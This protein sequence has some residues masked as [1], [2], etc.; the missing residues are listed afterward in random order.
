[1]NKKILICSLLI[2]TVSF[3]ADW[4]YVTTGASESF[5][6]DRSFYK[7]DVKNKTVDV[8]SKTVKKKLYGD[9]FYTSSKS[10]DR[11]SCS[12]KE[13]KGLA[14]VQYHDDGNVLKSTTV[15]DRNF[16]IIFP[17]SIAESI[18]NVACVTN[19]KGFKFTKN[20]LE[21]K[22][23]IDMDGQF[24][25]IASFKSEHVPNNTKNL[26]PNP[27][28]YNTM[29][30]WSIA[31]YKYYGIE[32]PQPYYITEPHGLVPKFS[33]YSTISTFENAIQSYAQKI[34]F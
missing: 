12:N 23:I 9:G 14:Y 3:G 28:D 34:K 27:I 6:V 1:M 2:S 5:Y 19:G 7:Y 15:S 8:W 16:S 24:S 30:E 10:L 33:N 11:Y 31:M 20:Q 13:T 32:Y 4:V 18:W 21:I 29:D 17:D 25:N 22:S 26:K